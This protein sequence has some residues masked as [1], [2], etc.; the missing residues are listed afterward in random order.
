MADGTC[1]ICGYGSTLGA[2]ESH[3]VIPKDITEQAGIT[4]SP[5]RMICCNCRRELET[6]YSAK[7][8]K[9]LYDDS[10]ARF[11]YK[12]P[13]E[14]VEEYEFVYKGFVDYKKRQKKVN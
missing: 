8:A 10:I 3:H 2:V 6:W 1:E 5:T 12:T 9:M 13:S 7:V 4:D 14:M 11:R